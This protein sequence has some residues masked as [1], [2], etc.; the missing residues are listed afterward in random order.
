M[1]CLAFLLNVL[2][3]ANTDEYHGPVFPDESIADADLSEPSPLPKRNPLLQRSISSTQVIFDDIDPVSPAMPQDFLYETEFDIQPV[4]S[5]RQH[6]IPRRTT[7][8]IDCDNTLFMDDGTYTQD[9]KWQMETGNGCGITDEYPFE[10]GGCYAGPIPLTFGMGLFDNL[11]LSA[12][13]TTF[14]TALNNGAGSIGIGESINW[15]TPITPQGTI[16]AQY[17]VRA[18]QGDNFSQSARSQCFMTA[19][20]FKRCDFI[21]LQGGVAFDWLRDYSHFGSVNFRQMRCELSLR[22]VRNLEFGFIGGFDAFRDR[23]TTPQIDALARARYAERYGVPA[24][25]DLGGAVAVQD[26]Y[27]FFA[28]KHLDNGGQ[29]EF[30]CGMTERG[31]LI[32]SALGEAAITDRLALNGSIS[33]LAPSAGQSI[34][35]N[36]RESWSMSLGVVL[37]FRG[38]AMSRSANLYRP[39]F[40][41]AGNNSFFSRIAGR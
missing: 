37:Y 27:L 31:D 40:D 23:P 35:G 39:M 7:Q 4:R 21:A 16:T 20:V 9:S 18:V 17:G 14:K 34:Y 3:V 6:R 8:I 32:M 13:T 2:P 33:M 1:L 41:V 11:M 10:M 22:S 36:Y 24:P 5:A 26:Y 15:S 38:G 25:L 12:E 19:G 28:R 30:R 29:M